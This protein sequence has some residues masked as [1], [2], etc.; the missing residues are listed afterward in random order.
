MKPDIWMNGEFVPW[1]KAC[2][3]PLSHSMQRGAT[4][5]ESIDCNEAVGGRAAIFRLREHIERLENSA[6]I[7]GIT[8]PYNMDEL[9]QAVIDTISRSGMKSCVIRPLAFYAGTTFG[10]YPGDLPITV[11]IGLG[12]PHAV[13]DSYRVNISHIHKIDGLSMPVK[14]K[15][16]G[17]YIGPMIAK[18]E[19]VK[20]GFDD[21]II[22]DRDGFI[23]EGA[24]SNI[25]I[26]EEGILFT[27]PEETIL[28]GITRN[29]I[30]VIAKKLGIGV[31]EDKF[32]AE[33]LKCADEV[34]LCSSG[35]EVTPILQVDDAVI[36]DGRPGAVTKQLHSFYT[37]VITGR[38][39]EFQDWLTYV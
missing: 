11:V 27:V 17:N 36:G 35:N 37:D 29:S 30:I 4:L 32:D 9:K 39:L 22:L 7:V 1:D 16:S 20:A 2:I 10:V 19:A 13:S 8:L 31:K 34:I 6:R 23:A 38:V 25:F 18:T 24:T 12:E 15:V 14:A 5:F 3:H 21:T 28:P 33:R 26:V